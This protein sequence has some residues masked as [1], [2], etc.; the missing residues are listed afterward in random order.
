MEEKKIEDA[1]KKHIKESKAMKAMP[2]FEVFAQ[3][4]N[5]NDSFL[6]LIAPIV[7]VLEENPG[8]NRI[9]QCEEVLAKIS[10]QLLKNSTLKGD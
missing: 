3:Y 2:I 10:S 7:K 6:D 1:A 4:I 9:Q 5:F 8:F